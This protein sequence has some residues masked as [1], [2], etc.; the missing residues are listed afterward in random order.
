MVESVGTRFPELDPLRHDPESAP[1]L[2]P[3]NLAGERRIELPVFRGQLRVP[4][5]ELRA[6]AR[7]PGSH[8][9]LA[10]ARGPVRVGLGVRDGHGAPLHAHLFL[11]GRPPEAERRGSALP[12]TAALPATPGLRP[13]PQELGSLPALEVGVEDEAALVRGANEH[14]AHRG[15]ARVIHGGERRGVR[16]GDIRAGRERGP[17]QEQPDGIGRLGHRLGTDLPDFSDGGTG[18]YFTPS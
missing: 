16:L 13:P 3:G 17:F 4:A 14:H 9:R 6:L 11:E 7:R 2:G 12:T 18:R 5:R 10:R 1:V 8:L 15:L